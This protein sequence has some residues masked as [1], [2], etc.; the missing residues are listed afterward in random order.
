LKIGWTAL[1]TTQARLRLDRGL[2]RGG[3]N[4]VHAHDPSCGANG[5]IFGES[6][7]SCGGVSSVIP[8]D[9]PGDSDGAQRPPQLVG[10]ALTG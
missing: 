7:A 4:R 5:G 6:Y 2:A 9:A 3:L 8:V 1:D 10:I